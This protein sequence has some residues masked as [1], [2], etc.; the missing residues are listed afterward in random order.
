[1][2]AGACCSQPELLPAQTDSSEADTASVCRSFAGEPLERE[3]FGEHV[4]Q[5]LA[6]G[7]EFGRAKA[8]LES[9]NRCAVL[10]A[11][12]QAACCG[13]YQ[14]RCCS[15]SHLG[16]VRVFLTASTKLACSSV[17]MAPAPCRTVRSSLPSPSLDLA[18]DMSAQTHA[19]AGAQCT[20]SCGRCTA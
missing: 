9:L 10:S 14:A 12:W 18:D 5:S 2:G 3:R 6:S 4:S 11:V 15:A 19:C 17:A 8:N 16:G 1:M 13:N 7:I 20:C